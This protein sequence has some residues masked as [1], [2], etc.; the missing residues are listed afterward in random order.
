MQTLLVICGP[1]AKL[2][3]EALDPKKCIRFSADHGNVLWDVAR[4]FNTDKQLVVVENRP[5]T[6]WQEFA[7]DE[8]Q[9]IF[10]G[11]LTP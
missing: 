1:S 4:A 3:M 10:V 7:N 6:S 5:N 11:M 9:V 2:L 8:I